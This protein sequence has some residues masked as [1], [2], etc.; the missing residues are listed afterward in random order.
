M[1]IL[2]N[3]N[4]IIFTKILLF[5]LTI[6]FIAYYF[7]KEGKD[8]RG[9]ELIAIA[10]VRGII[11]L[12]LLLNLCSYYTFS[13]ISDPNIYTSVI[14]IVYDLTLLMIIINILVLRKIR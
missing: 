2:G 3:M 9:R 8:E 4:F 14:T 13:I 1:K 6:V 12:F 11:L 7:S 5:V 10:C